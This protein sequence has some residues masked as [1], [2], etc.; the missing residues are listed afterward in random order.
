MKQDKKKEIKNLKTLD[1]IKD[2]LLEMFKTNGTLLQKDI[3]KAIEHL[4]LSDE[5]NDDLLDW[6][7]KNVFKRNWTC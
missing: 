1:E 4:E 7:S 2:D 6:I 3:D 5:D